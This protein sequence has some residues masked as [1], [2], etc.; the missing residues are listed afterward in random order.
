MTRNN[1]KFLHLADLHLGQEFT[2][3][4]LKLPYEKAQK[5]ARDQQDILIRAVELAKEVE[6]EIILIAGDLWEESGL[7]VETI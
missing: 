5:R 3:G 2:G 6:A 4:R 7:S 1:L